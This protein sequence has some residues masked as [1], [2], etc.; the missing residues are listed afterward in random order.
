MFDD[1]EDDESGLLVEDERTGVNGGLE[2]ETRGEGD[3]ELIVNRYESEEEG[4]NVVWPPTVSP[5]LS[6]KQRDCS[7]NCNKFKLA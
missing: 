4:F 7:K 5:K 6:S 3:G 2:T 1:G